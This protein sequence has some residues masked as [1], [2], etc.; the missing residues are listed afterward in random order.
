LASSH[1]KWTK[2][3]L[4]RAALVLAQ[5]QWL[6]KRGHHINGIYL[7]AGVGESVRMSLLG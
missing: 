2:L 3:F 5:V 4:Q 6:T 7:A 1:L